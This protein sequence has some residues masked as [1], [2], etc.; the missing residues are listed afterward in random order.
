MQ[1]VPEP[2]P[3]ATVPSSPAAP[4][5]PP[6][7]D[8]VSLI[9][10]IEKERKLRL[11][12]LVISDRPVAVGPVSQIPFQ[13]TQD[14]PRQ[15]LDHLQQIGHVPRLGLF[16]YSRGGDTS[17]PWVLVSLLR[18]YCDELEVIIPYRA[19]SAAT[20]VALGADQI[21]MGRHGQL[22]PIDP[23][24]A[25]QEA[26]QID[27]AKSRNITI[28][29]EDITS[30]IKLVKEGVGITDQRELG[31][32]F[33][34]LSAVVSPVTL[35]TINRQQAYIRMV[36]RKL[37]GSRKTP[38]QVAEVDRIVEGLISQTFFHLHVINRVE[39]TKDIGLDNIPAIDGAFDDKIWALFLEYERAL[40]L[41][42]V[43]NGAKMFSPMDPDQRTID[44]VIGA[45]IE[46]ATQQSR[47]S[48]RIEITRNRAIPQGLNVNLNVSLPPQLAAPGANIPQQ[49]QALIPQLQGAIQAL[50]QAEIRRQAPVLGYGFQWI[51]DWE[52]IGDG[53]V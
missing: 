40:E 11:I 19:H 9:E 14:I 45:L 37:L 49:L 42:S 20:M 25:F 24:L 10:A 22:G 39:A 43:I 50:V 44:G 53:T 2:T 7:A 18:E 6:N 29:V 35:G 30:F 21:L 23:T 8:R 26:N 33:G 47:L 48:G 51:G 16:L 13:I 1:D 28:A 31:E 3:Q 17:V 4:P 5:R 32:A 15:V 34:R 27:P 41:R 36:A 12:S 38:P 46:T 52:P